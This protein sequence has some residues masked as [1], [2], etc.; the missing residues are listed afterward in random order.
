MKRRTSSVD[1]APAEA[2]VPPAPKRQRVSRACDQCRAA[3]EKCDGIQPLCFPCASQNRQCSWE[4]PK[5]KR[6]VQTGYIRTLEL[7]LGWIFDKIPGSEEALHGLL[8]HEGGQGRALLV[9]KDTSAGNRLHRRWRKSIV[10]QE[11]ERV[12]SGGDT[13]GAKTGKASPV[14]DESDSS[15]DDPEQPLK[16]ETSGSRDALPPTRIDETM[17]TTALHPDVHP[18]N[19]G[20]ERRHPF[21]GCLATITD[22]G[23]APAQPGQPDQ[24][25]KLTKLPPNCW[26]LLDVYFSYTHCWF[27]ILEKGLVQKACWSYPGEGLDL[28]EEDAPRSGSHAEL[29]A[30]LALAAYQDEASQPGHA[31]GDFEGRMHPDDIYHAARRL[32]PPDSGNFETRHVNAILLLTLV[33]I[34]RREYT[35]AWILTGLATRV[36][37]ALNLQSRPM[38]D[39]S[40]RPYHIYMACFMLDTLVATK[41]NQPPH[42][43]AIDI[44]STTPSGEDDQDEWDIWTPCQGFGPV[45][46]PGPALRSPAH[47]MSSFAAFFSIHRIH[48]ATVFGPNPGPEQTEPYLTQVQ[49][50]IGGNQSRRLFVSF[51]TNGNAPPYQVPSIFLLRLAFLCCGSQTQVYT[52]SLPSTVLQCAEEHILNFGAAIPPLFSLYMDLLSQQY[53]SEHLKGDTR[54][55]WKKVQTSI[56]SVWHPQ[57]SRPRSPM[58]HKPPD[59]APSYMQQPSSGVLYPNASN[60]PAVIQ[61]LPTPSSHYADTPADQAPPMIGGEVYHDTSLSAM[62]TFPNTSRSR[63]PMNLMNHSSQTAPGAVQYDLADLSPQHFPNHG[64]PSF[65]SATFDYDSILDDIASLDRADRMGSDP[66]FMANLGF[67]PGSDLTELLAHDFTGI[68]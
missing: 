27:P 40:R 59:R 22:S 28:A 9:G 21:D 14:A 6:G 32:I 43:R 58:V 30:A 33:N 34:G 25:R 12:L 13:A 3:R 68:P 44:A 1:D 65:S 42:L 16:E 4:E 45:R 51:I 36:A 47:S 26:R 39:G 63:Q 54:D 19:L 56:D 7:S 38:G 18:S 15:A 35:A 10:H 17:M 61:Q 55:R 60:I 8:T 23:H 50:A 31:R 29:W 41:I 46:P 48:C 11:I 5:K 20:H 49:Q 64:R 53:N 62:M 2:E 66:Q 24:C 52:E 67:A 37:L 57:K